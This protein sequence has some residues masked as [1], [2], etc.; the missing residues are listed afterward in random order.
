MAEMRPDGDRVG[1]SELRPIFAYNS[2]EYPR[3]RSGGELEVEVGEDLS[4]H[5]SGWAVPVFTG[6]LS[7]EFVKELEEVS[8]ESE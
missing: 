1:T 5:L 3:D 4:V 8:D 7:D 2:G 6:R